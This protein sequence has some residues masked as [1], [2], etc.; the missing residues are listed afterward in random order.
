[1][2]DHGAVSMAYQM[3][4]L[5]RLL[6]IHEKVAVPAGMDPVIWDAFMPDDNP[7]DAA[8]VLLGRKLYFD[9]RLSRDG[10]VSC[11][12]CH[13]VLRGFTDQRATSE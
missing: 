10:T 8:R 1:M 11:A 3:E 6:P 13:D 2:D 4:M 9:K 5:D 7:Q 12:T